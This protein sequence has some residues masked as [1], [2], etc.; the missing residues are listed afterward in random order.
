MDK[1][2]SDFLSIVISLLI[3][4]AVTVMCISFTN[5][6]RAVSIRD[7]DLKALH[8][9]M[10]EERQWRKY[11]GRVTGA[12]VVDFITR[13]KDSYDIVIHDS[14]LAANTRINSFLVGGRLI[15]GLNEQRNIPEHFWEVTFVYDHIIGGRGDFAY[16]ATLLY[17]GQLAPEFQGGVQVRSGVITGIEYR[18]I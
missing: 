12:D 5:E 13:H 11:E 14:R 17:D 10:R 3:I 4:S 16:N 8:A 7:N 2:L 15:L 9:E 6:A 18:R 1:G